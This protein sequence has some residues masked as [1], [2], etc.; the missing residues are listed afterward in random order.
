MAVCVMHTV[1]M[2][3]GLLKKR[4]EHLSEQRPVVVLPKGCTY[5]MFL[6]PVNFM[7]E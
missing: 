3:I 7:V 1:N 2:K 6:S 5:C 4:K